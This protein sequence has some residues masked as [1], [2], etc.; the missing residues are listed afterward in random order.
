MLLDYAGVLPALRERYAAIL[1][2]FR[3]RRHISLRFEFRLLIFLFDFSLPFFAAAAIFADFFARL[4]ASKPFH[5]AADLFRHFHF[6]ALM[7]PSPCH[8][9]IL[10]MMPRRLSPCL[11]PCRRFTPYAADDAIFAFCC[12]LFS[13]AAAIITPPAADL[14]FAA[15]T[16]RAAQAP[17]CAVIA[18]DAATLRLMPPPPLMPG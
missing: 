17:R 9:F 13:H 2:P 5:A 1:P 16:A 7:P 4:F 3:R 10:L 14:I 18:A 12:R 6:A 15:I 8:F 11:M